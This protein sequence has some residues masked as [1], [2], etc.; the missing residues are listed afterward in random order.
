MLAQAKDWRFLRSDG[1]V[2]EPVEFLHQLFQEYFAAEYLR[3]RLAKGQDYDSILG[4]HPFVETWNETI[5]MLAGIYDRPV[6]LVMWLGARVLERNDSQAAFLLQQCWETTSAV[7]SD[8]ARRAIVNALTMVLDTHF[9]IHPSQAYSKAIE[10]AANAWTEVSI[11]DQ[12]NAVN[13]VYK[14]YATLSLVLRAIKALGRIGDEQAVQSLMNALR[15]NNADTRWTAAEALGET[16]NIESVEPLI[17]ALHDS[18]AG[19]RG[20]AALALESVMHYK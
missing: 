18:E 14:E 19:V 2:G 15:D 10:D 12:E 13:A 7:K 9:N 4:E 5:V 3:Q 20:E 16:R 8:Q 11:V 6:D 1:Q 17:I